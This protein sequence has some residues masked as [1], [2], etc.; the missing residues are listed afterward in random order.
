MFLWQHHRCLLMQPIDQLGDSVQIQDL[1]QQY[2]MPLE[3]KEM[4]KGFDMATK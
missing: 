2:N 3:P 1:T 4:D